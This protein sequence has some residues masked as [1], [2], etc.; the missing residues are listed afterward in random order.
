MI[1]V[2]TIL[3]IVL[4]LAG[5]VIINQQYHIGELR[6]DRNSWRKMYR[7]SEKYHSQFVQELITATSQE[8]FDEAVN[9][10]GNKTLQ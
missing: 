5:L 2:I 3:C 9:S 10:E 1:T 4:F 8:D 7:D 6:F